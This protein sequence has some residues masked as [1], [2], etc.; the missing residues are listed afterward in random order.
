MKKAL[1][2]LFSFLLIIPMLVAN[3]STISLFQREQ[4]EENYVNTPSPTGEGQNSIID[5]IVPD[6]PQNDDDK[7]EIQ[8]VSTIE[9]VKKTYEEYFTDNN[10]SSDIADTTITGTGTKDDP[11]I[12]YS[13]ED[14]WYF[15]KYIGGLHRLVGRYFELGDD[16]ILNDEVFDG[17][18]NI[19]GGDGVI[20]NWSVMYGKE[21]HFD[22]KGHTIKGLYMNYPETGGIA[23]L[24]G[25]F[26]SVQNLN[27]ES[28]YIRSGGSKGSVIAVTMGPSVVG[29]LKNCRVGEGLV[30]TSY[31][32]WLAGLVS[33]CVI[34]GII[35]EN[36]INEAT[37]VAEGGQ[38]H[39]GG[40]AAEIRNGV[41][42]I[43]CKNYGSVSG[44]RGVGGIVGTQ[45][46]AEITDCENYGKITSTSNSYYVG[47]ITGE[48]TNS[49][50]IFNC[51]NYGE[52]NGAGITGQQGSFLLIQ[53][54][55]N[56]GEVLN[57]IYSL[58]SSVNTSVVIDNCANYSRTPTNYFGSGYHVTI[59]NCHITA[60]QNLISAAINAKFINCKITIDES[61]ANQTI[62]SKSKV[63]LRDCE[64]TTHSN[65]LID[66]SSGGSVEFE[67]VIWN[68]INKV[69]SDC[70]LVSDEAL[71]STFEKNGVIVQNYDKSTKSYDNSFYGVDFKRFYISW[72]T[73][74]I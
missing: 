4:N 5:D 69:K 8:P 34:Q 49:C 42:I 18:G 62:L 25:E 55:E 56:H 31:N 32:Y 38:Y 48:C 46:N 11:Y 59:K 65:V 21:Y 67:N 51:K 20:Y 7:N 26:H 41:K 50:V 47:G 13:G 71:V 27:F 52:V 24:H 14:M 33:Q 10:I 57:G 64:I 44:K 12:I 9:Y 61:S 40:I 54:C 23:F 36:C 58:S 74:K 2:I 29:R 63:S 68:S 28:F 60:C 6:Y 70:R 22:G 43:N 53:K 72:K 35:I 1:K 17:E 45:N 39:T 19:S 73:G 16:I 15:S 66:T 30:T 37:V 3:L